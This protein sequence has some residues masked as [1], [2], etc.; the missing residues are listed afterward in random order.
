MIEDLDNTGEMVPRLRAKISGEPSSS[1]LFLV[2][3]LFKSGRY[4]QCLVEL[5][6]ALRDNPELGAAHFM[7]GL[8]LAFRGDLE[9]SVESLE[10]AV[11]LHGSEA[12]HWWALAYVA[13]L[14]DRRERALVAVN[15]AI[16]LEEDA[17]NLAKLLV[18]RSD[19][20]TDMGRPD[21]AVATLRTAVEQNPLA[22]AP[23]YKLGKLLA[24]C[25]PVDEALRELVLACR[26]NPLNVDACVALG[27]VLQKA[28]RGAE[29][30][31]RYK[32]AVVN[33]PT[34]AEPYAKLATSFLAQ[35]HAYEAIAFF[36]AALKVDARQPD[37]YIEL[38]RLY[39]DQGRHDEAADVLE[40]ALELRKDDPDAR[41][42]LEKART[43]AA[44]RQDVP[45]PGVFPPEKG[46]LAARLQRFE[47]ML[48]DFVVRCTT[49]RVEHRDDEI[50]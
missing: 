11:R 7:K 19:I 8:L 44:D 43:M 35:S 31:S 13:Y 42:L 14:L 23:R 18:L 38:G 30:I 4:A 45:G 37:V 16:E 5:E 2:Q 48:T 17:N 28:G 39:L 6:R 26:L 33:F 10:T 20:L 15:R 32:T 1:R 36:N 40:A 49:V 22:L 46:D 12:N 24:E 21:E 34:K 50:D 3:S 9:H 29:A 27:D 41:W 25:A 47:L